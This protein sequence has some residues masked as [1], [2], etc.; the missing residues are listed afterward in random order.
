MK[1]T[2][3]NPIKAPFKKY[4]GLI[5][6]RTTYIEEKIIFFIVNWIKVYLYTNEITYQFWCHNLVTPIVIRK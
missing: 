1:I 2:F 5:Q 6:T 3:N 4:T